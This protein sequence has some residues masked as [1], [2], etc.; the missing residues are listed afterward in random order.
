M[1]LF[2]TDPPH[3]CERLA[4]I[5]GQSNFLGLLSGSEAGPDTTEDMAAL[6]MSRAEGAVPEALEIRW[7]GSIRHKLAFC[8]MVFD[9]LSPA[10]KDRTWTRAA[11]LD[12]F[13]LFREGCC[14]EAQAKARLFKVR[15]E[16]Y[17]AV[18]KFAERTM[19]AVAMDAE[20]P[21]IRARF[22]GT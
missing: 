21:W 8:Q 18:R 19:L 6:A 1:S 20:R 14:A 15:K 5:E 3:P 4:R 7:S 10:D 13:Q 11:I 2:S 22:S 9:L 16:D 17:L 12:G